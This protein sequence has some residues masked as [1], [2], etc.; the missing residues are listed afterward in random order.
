MARSEDCPP[1]SQ[2]MSLARRTCNLPMLR[3]TV[4][5]ILPAA[6]GS[7]PVKT[8]LICSSTVVFPARSTPR[9]RTWNSF[10]RK[11]SCQKPKSRE[12]CVWQ[13]GV[14]NCDIRTSP[15][16]HRTMGRSRGGPT[17]FWTASAG[18]HRS[19]SPFASRPARCIGCSGCARRRLALPPAAFYWPHGSLLR[20]RL[21][22][23]WAARAV[24]W[25]PTGRPHTRHLR[26]CTS[27]PTRRPLCSGS[28]TG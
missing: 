25:S 14:S 18:I 7:R 23:S 6:N 19:C 26:S 22:M 17:Y 15:A 5:A 3:P 21:W 10:C 4:G 20:S 24:R 1:R 12:N 13:D 16:G 28:W 8:A 9:M 11:S 2:K 27:S